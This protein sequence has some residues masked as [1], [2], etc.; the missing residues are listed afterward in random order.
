M[1]VDWSRLTR[2]AYNNRS[3]LA[4]AFLYKLLL[5]SITYELTNK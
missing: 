2:Q 4:R 1:A 3:A 5:V